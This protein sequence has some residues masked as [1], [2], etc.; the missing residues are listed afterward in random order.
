[1]NY[2]VVSN[3]NDNEQNQ[4]YALTESAIKELGVNQG[5]THTEL[6]L[7]EQG[8]RIIEVNGREAHKS[9]KLTRC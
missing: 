1:M 8:A 4:I 2:A 7:T 3:L 5:I 9:M 6:K